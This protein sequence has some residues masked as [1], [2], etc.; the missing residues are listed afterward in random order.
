LEG[1]WLSTGVPRSGGWML[2]DGCNINKY[3]C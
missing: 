2:D 3:E 1:G